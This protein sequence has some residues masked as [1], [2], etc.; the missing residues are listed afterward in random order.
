MIFTHSF[1]SVCKAVSPENIPADS[2]KK[3]ILKRLKPLTADGISLEAFQLSDQANTLHEKGILPL[4]RI[5]SKVS[6]FSSFAT[7]TSAIKLL[8]SKAMSGSGGKGDV[9]A[10]TESDNI[11]LEGEAL[12]Q[13]AEVTSLDPFLL[14]VPL[15]IKPF[16]T[17]TQNDSKTTKKGKSSNDDTAIFEFEH[18]FPSECE[19]VSDENTAKVAK[20]HFSRI[21][22]DLASPGT[23]DRMRDPHL[24]FYISKILDPTT[25]DA[26]CRSLR[27]GTDRFPGLVKV[28]LDMV[29]INFDGTKSNSNSVGKRSGRFIADDDDDDD[30]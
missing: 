27:D 18:S 14:A 17:A 10:A 22:S 16:R 11:E 24:L 23:K 4:V 26:L 1:C 21:I 6:S 25:R 20:L 19:M 2:P 12:I 15:P 5:R 8:A 13:N 28:A 7:K 3:K 30:E 9:K 29:K